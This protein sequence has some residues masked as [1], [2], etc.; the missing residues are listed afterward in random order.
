VRDGASSEAYTRLARGAKKIRDVERR[1][2][3]RRLAAEFDAALTEL[4]AHRMAA[5]P[6][7]EELRALGVVIAIEGESSDFPLQLD[8]LETFTRHRVVARA[9]KWLLLSV[10]PASVDQPERALVWVSDLYTPIAIQLS[11]PVEA[12]VVAI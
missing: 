1:A 4:D 2:H 10:H 5:L 7:D 6:T 12:A 3:G 9:P 8:S 11:I